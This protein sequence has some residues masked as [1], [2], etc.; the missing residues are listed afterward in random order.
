MSPLSWEWQWEIGHYIFFGLFYAA[1]GMVGLGLGLVALKTTLNILRGEE[2]EHHGH[3]EPH[4][5]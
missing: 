3:G 2:P 1:L 5:H 4:G